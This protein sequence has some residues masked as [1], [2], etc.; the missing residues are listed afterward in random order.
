[1]DIF[2]HRNTPNK[3]EVSTADAYQEFN[4]NQESKPPPSF[5]FSNEEYSKASNVQNGSGGNKN[6]TTSGE[7]IY[8]NSTDESKHG[9]IQGND[10]II[11]KNNSLY[12]SEERGKA[13]VRKGNDYTVVTDRSLHGRGDGV[14]PPVDHDITLV[15]NSLYSL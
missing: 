15:D 5:A 4:A 9:S 14:S 1:M 11:L 2:F 6:K 13:S 10:D 12:V 7:N 3:S 8:D